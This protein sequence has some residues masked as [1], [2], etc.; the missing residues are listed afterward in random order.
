MYQQTPLQNYGY[1]QAPSRPAYANTTIAQAGLKG[2]PVSSF[3][4]ARASIIDF[5]GSIFY[6]PDL[7]NKCIYTKQINA[8]GTAQINMYELKAIPIVQEQKPPAVDFNLFVTKD[9]FNQAITQLR[10]LASVKPNVQVSPPPEVAAVAEK[11]PL[12]LNF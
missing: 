9:E 10:E 1:Y 8:D 7:A 2:R 11:T 6:F 4:E 12:I 3:E 5:D